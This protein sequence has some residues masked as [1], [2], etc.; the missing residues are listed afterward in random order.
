[1]RHDYLSNGVT[2]HTFGQSILEGIRGEDTNCVKS[3][4]KS[5]KEREVDVLVRLLVSESY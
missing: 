2:M 5:L 4:I 1:M 3:E